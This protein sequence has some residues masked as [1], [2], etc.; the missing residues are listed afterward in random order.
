MN[1]T[2]RDIYQQ[3]AKLTTKHFLLSFFDITAVLGAFDV[4]PRYVR[5]Y[6]NYL[7]ARALD[8]KN[9]YRLLYRLKSA[10]LIEIYYEG[11][12]QFVELTNIG[13][14]RVIKYFFSDEKVSVPKYWDGKWRIVIFDIPEDKKA[15]RN[16]VRDMLN[17]IG[18]Y[19]LQKSVYVY[20]H[21]C[22]N[23][24]R[25]LE[26][27]FDANQ[28]IQFIIAERLETETDLI[29]LFHERGIINNIKK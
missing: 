29:T 15:I 11:K 14:R 13:R 10:K 3:L 2:K 16:I 12:E 25:Y 23:I 4:R 27:T 20:P 22:I 19:Q 7:D 28:Y 26:E 6:D 24:I 9:F 17:R 5:E 18:F 8:Y 21:D 1:Q